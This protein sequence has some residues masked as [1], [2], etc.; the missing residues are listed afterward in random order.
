MR[1]LSYVGA[2]ALLAASVACG[3][4]K[5]VA[6]VMGP[7][8]LNM[9]DYGKVAAIVTFTSEGAKGSLD[10]LATRRFSERVLSA[11]RGVELLELDSAPVLE[12]SGEHEFGPESAKAVGAM[13]HVP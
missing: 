5:K 3:G 4:G 1:V 9:A 6:T 8:R 13:K 12:K 11:S 10:D 2:I 7:P